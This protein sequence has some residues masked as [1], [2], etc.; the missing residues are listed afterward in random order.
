MRAAVEMPLWKLDLCSVEGRLFELARR[1]GYPA[2]DFVAAFMG[3]KVAEQLDHPYNRYQ[4][5]GEEYL[6]ESLVDECGLVRRRCLDRTDPE[7][8]FWMGYTYRYWHYLTGETSRKIY[9]IADF[10]R[11]RIVYAGYHTLSCEAAVERLRSGEGAS[12]SATRN[13]VRRRARRRS[14]AVESVI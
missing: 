11:M 8:L 4:W 5:A 3:S 10:R 12:G 1:K 14:R 2:A 7:A 6:L 9:G 13:A